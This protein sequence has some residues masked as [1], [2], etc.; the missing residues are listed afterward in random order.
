MPDMCHPYLKGN[1]M[2]NRS[3]Y[4]TISV[5]PWNVRK[6]D[7]ITLFDRTVYPNRQTRVI[8]T[9]VQKGII[10]HFSGKR[11]YQIFWEMPDKKDIPWWVHG[12]WGMWYSD[13][14]VEVDR[15]K[16]KRGQNGQ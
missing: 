15:K 7:E 10:G 6:G 3:D 9:E 2:E 11:R 8:V 12:N 5:S 16:V 1:K 14:K 4:R 13:D